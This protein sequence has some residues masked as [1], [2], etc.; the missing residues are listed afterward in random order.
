VPVRRYAG[1]DDL[2]AMQAAVQRIWSPTSRWHIGDLAWGRFM[3]V[4]REAEWPTALWT[5][6]NGDVLAW[7]WIELPG[8]LDLLV[9]PAHPQLTVEVLQWFHQVATADDYTVTVLD[10]EHHLVDALDSMSYQPQSEGPF[11]NHCWM[12][13]AGDLPSPKLPEGFVL[14]H[15]QAGDVERRA[16]AH[17]LAFDP[18]RV[19]AESYT[20]VMAAWPYR[21]DLDWIVE[22][23]NGDFAAFALAWL[24]D[25]NSVGELEPVGTDPKYRGLGLAHAV[26]LAALHALKNAG[27]DT[28][29]VYPRGDADYPVPARLYDRLGFVRQA[30]TVSYARPMEIELKTQEPN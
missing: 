7:G 20:N 12:S 9:D 13:L 18:S 8:H 22:A 26:S 24:D 15:V 16:H 30:H 25:V 21:A 14:R 19:S 27:A 1:V 29:V 6:D 4:G 28:A 17:Q 5:D 3:H 2:R 10:T 23:P 11:F